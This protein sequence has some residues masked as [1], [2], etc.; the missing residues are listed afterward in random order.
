MFEQLF[1]VLLFLVVILFIF[2][3]EHTIESIAH[4]ERKI[5]KIEEILKYIISNEQE[6]WDKQNHEQMLK[7]LSEIKK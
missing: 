7:E 5:N 1:N 3:I 6:K 4:I 2:K